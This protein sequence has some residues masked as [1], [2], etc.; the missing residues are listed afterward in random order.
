ME[1]RLKNLSTRTD[2][3]L[4]GLVDEHRCKEEESNTMIDHLLSLQNSQPEYYTNQII[5]GLI[6][7]SAV[8]TP[9]LLFKN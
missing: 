8:S 1:K 9:S 6:L 5:K 4:Q 2:A 3:F 7:V